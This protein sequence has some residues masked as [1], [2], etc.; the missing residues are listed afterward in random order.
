MLVR[1]TYKQILHV[2]QHM[3]DLDWREQRALRWTDDRASLAFDL[4]SFDGPKWAAL[5]DDEPVYVF[6]VEPGVDAKLN[7]WGFGTELFRRAAYE[8]SK[9]IKC[10]LVPTIEPEPGKARAECLCLLEKEDAARWLRWLGA[11]EDATRCYFEYGRTG[12][13]F[14][15]FVWR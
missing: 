10:V 1:A 13:T 2:T 15:L 5:I 6:G 4:A 9:F 14:K 7:V 12:E 3:R 8:V 11:E